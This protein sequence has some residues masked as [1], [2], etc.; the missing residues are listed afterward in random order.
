M[1]D[2][3]DSYVQGSGGI[4]LDPSNINNMWPMD[5]SAA[6]MTTEGGGQTNGAQQTATSSPQQ[7][8]QQALNANMFANTGT[9]GNGQRFA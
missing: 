4:N 9:P 5:F 1:Q 7:Q 2:A 8:A 3:W 6:G